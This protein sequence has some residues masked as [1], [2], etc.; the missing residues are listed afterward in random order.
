MPVGEGPKGTT[1]DRLGCFPRQTMY[2]EGDSEI[3]DTLDAALTGCR[4]GMSGMG[5]TG[6]NTLFNWSIRRREMRKLISWGKPISF[7]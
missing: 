3:F 7:P 6:T 2:N 4:L 5:N 1:R